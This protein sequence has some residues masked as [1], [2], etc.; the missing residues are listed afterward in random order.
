M[1]LIQVKI[2]NS[3]H[4]SQ[5]YNEKAISQ[6]QQPNA[7]IFPSLFAFE[8]EACTAH[9]LQPKAKN[10]S[11]INT[12]LYAGFYR[13]ERQW[14]RRWWKRQCKP[15]WPHRHINTERGRKTQFKTSKFCTRLQFAILWNFIATS[16]F[17]DVEHLFFAVAR[18]WKAANFAFLHSFQYWPEYIYWFNHQKSG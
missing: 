9:F 16:L 14:H 13:P 17:I 12:I 11:N 5:I 4:P 15:L 8:T 18:Q 2:T 6:Y 1:S 7:L 10:P 3:S